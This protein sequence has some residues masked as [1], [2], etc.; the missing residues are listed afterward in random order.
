[1]RN[2]LPGPNAYAVARLV[3]DAQPVTMMDL[4]ETLARCGV[5]ACH[6]RD[7]DGRSNRGVSRLNGHSE[8]DEVGGMSYSQHQART[9]KRLF[10]GQIR[11]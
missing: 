2:A 3:L 10:R 8:V 5:F 9:H 4:V 1:M 11:F 7:V 6:G